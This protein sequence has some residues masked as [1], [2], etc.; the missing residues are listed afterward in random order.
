MAR[1]ARFAWVALL[2]LLLAPVLSWAPARAA[3]SGGDPVVGVDASIAFFDNG[4]GLIS[5]DSST[6]DGNGVGWLGFDTTGLAAGNYDWLDV[7]LGGGYVTGTTIVPSNGDCGDNPK[8]L[9]A[10]VGQLPAADASASSSDSTGASTDSSTPDFPAHHQEHSLSCEYASIYIATSYFGNPI[11]EDTSLNAVP[12]AVDPHY[13][14]R[15]DIDGPYGS[16]DDYGVYAEPLATLLSAYGY[17]GTVSYGAD[18]STLEGFLD[19]N[20]PTLVWIATRGDDGFYDTNAYGDRFKLVPWEHV[21]VAYAYD[22]AG[23]W[24]S[25][26]GNGLLEHLNWDWFLPAWGA[27]DGMALAV[28]PA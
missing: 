3:D 1:S 28:S 10:S 12:S 16:T 6:T 2:A 25:D 8:E 5:Q 4:G 15:G 22:D 13:G 9:S 23:V 21:V 24:V 20:Q 7:N 27:L 19:A 17:T 14:F 18:A 26:P 11:S